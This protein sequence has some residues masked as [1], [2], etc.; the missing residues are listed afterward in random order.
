MTEQEPT[1]LI[2]MIFELHMTT[3]NKCASW[4]YDFEETIHVY[5]DKP[6]FN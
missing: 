3:T 4:W 1:E 5:C 6:S 2:A